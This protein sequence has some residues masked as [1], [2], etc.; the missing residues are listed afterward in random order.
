MHRLRLALAAF[1]LAAFPLASCLAA[2]ISPECKPVIEAMEKTLR[3]NHTTTSTH[4]SETVHGVTVDGVAYLQ[5]KGAWRKS[6]ISI[7]ENID[8]SRE[9]LRDAKAFICKVMPDTAV[10][11]R[12][13]STYVTHTI[14]DD[15]TQDG[16]IAVDKATGLA[17]SV[18]NRNP[19]EPALDLVTHYG[20]ADV[21]APM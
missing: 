9:N 16:R 3:A 2:E 6:P 21:K 13:A 17:L 15:G 5:I 11:G 18:E 19:G 12:P 8:M 1:I 20:Y 10:D 14:T 4:G 7:Q